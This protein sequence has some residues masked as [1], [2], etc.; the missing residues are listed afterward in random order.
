MMSLTTGLNQ[1]GISAIMPISEWLTSQKHLWWPKYTYF[2]CS[3]IIYY[4]SYYITFILYI[5]TRNANMVQQPELIHIYS[6]L[7]VGSD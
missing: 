3:S 4:H 5:S 1:I 6:R 2:L 7:Y